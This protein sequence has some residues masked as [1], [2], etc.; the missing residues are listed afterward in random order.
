MRAVMR[1]VPPDIAA[2]RRRTGADRWDEVWQGVLHMNPAPSVAHMRLQGD[3]FRLLDR[4]VR[5]H[6]LGEL[7]LTL[8]VAAPGRWPDDFRIP[9]I[10][11][12]A[13]GQTGGLQATH[14]EGGPRVVVELH[15]PDDETYEKLDFYAGVG[16]GEVLVIDVPTK[17]VEIFAR[18]GGGMALVRAGADGWHLCEGL[19]LEL[20]SEEKDGKPLLSLRE[21]GSERSIA[22]L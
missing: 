9:D 16:V 10:L 8:N 22:S 6:G 21:A 17:R 20:R 18:T 13:P 15:S 2:W 7:L 11:V 3:L 12:V 14:F 19:G 4:H 5:A 1:L